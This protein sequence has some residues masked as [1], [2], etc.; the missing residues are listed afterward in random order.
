MK[1]PR[2]S[3][4]IFLTGNVFFIVGYDSLDMILIN[5]H[6]NYNAPKLY[7]TIWFVRPHYVAVSSRDRNIKLKLR[8]G[9][10]S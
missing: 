9:N 5:M 10:K 6:E 2:K 8:I 7:P 4:A 3:V 1:M